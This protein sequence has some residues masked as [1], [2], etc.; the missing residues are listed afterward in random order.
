M[1]EKKI[2]FNNMYWLVQ[3]DGWYKVFKYNDDN[4]TIQKDFSV[5]GMFEGR[6]IKEQFKNAVLYANKFYLG[7]KG[8]SDSNNHGDCTLDIWDGDMDK[9]YYMQ[10][11]TSKYK[12]ALKK[13][14]KEEV[15]EIEKLLEEY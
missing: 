3:L 2:K 15:K 6:T 11:A 12:E 8:I 1:I 14:S 5:Q 7:D 10:R 9:E 13:L 4:T